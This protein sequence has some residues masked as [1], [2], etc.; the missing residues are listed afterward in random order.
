RL[1]K[2]AE[3]ASITVSLDSEEAARS[4]SAAVSK[5]G[6]KVGVLAELDVG[7]GRCGVSNEVEL[8]RLARKITSLPGLEFKGVMFFPGHFGVVPEQRSA[9]RAQ[10]LSTQTN[11][12]RSTGKFLHDSCVFLRVSL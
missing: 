4:I 6:V 3:Q 2:I 8:L 10:L 9:M 11:P 1:A 7:F 12:Q 5:Q